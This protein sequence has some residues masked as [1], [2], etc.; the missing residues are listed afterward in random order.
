MIRY[1]DVCSGYSAFTLASAGLGFRCVGYSEI[2][3]FPRAVLEQRHGAVLV[4]WDHRFVPGSNTTPLFG[5]FTKIESHHVGP[6]DLLAGGTP[7]Q[8]FSVAGKR[9]GL[10]DPRGNLTLEFLALAR[11]VRARWLVWE[12]V[13]G[14]LSHDSGRT[15]G[16]FLRLLGELG[17]GW[18]YRVLDAQYIR[19]DGHEGA[20]PQRRRR[21]F[22][23]AHLGDAAG[24]AAVLFERE[25]LRGDPAPCRQAGEGASHAVAPSLVSS[26]RGV[27]R[28]GDGS[29]ALI[30]ASVAATLPAGGNSTGGARQPGMSAET[31]GTMLVAHSLRAEGFDASEDGTGR[32]TPLVPV[33]VH[34]DAINRTGDAL[35]PSVDASGVARLRDAGMGVS[36]GSAFGLTTGQPHAV[37]FR[38]TPNDGAYETG[39]VAGSLTTGTDRSAQALVQPIAFAQNSRDEVR[40]FGD[41]GQTV[42]ALA[43][44]PGMKQTCYVADQWAVRRLTPTE[45]E[46]LMGVPD[47]FTAITYRGKPAADGPRYKALGNSQAVNVMRWIA[48][49]LADVIAAQDGAEARAA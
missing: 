37:A 40:L 27:E 41:D 10:D 5:D 34:A 46:R 24:P 18:A 47:G 16:T 31:A 1:L 38:I 26:G 35:T 33:C 48:R 15:M 2:E 43:A 39:G 28:T 20:V 44:E 30:A 8:A 42:G 45:C 22:V 14:F 23:V 21:L 13:P 3:A 12:N 29:E 6:V 32:G 9:L 17:Y 19:V 7:C 25:S 49:G 36:E 4:E 11:R